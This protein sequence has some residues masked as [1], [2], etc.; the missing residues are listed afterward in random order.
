MVFSISG[1]IKET[2]AH[3]LDFVPKMEQSTP[4]GLRY[5]FIE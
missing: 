3:L 4:T 2:I 1:T 5:R